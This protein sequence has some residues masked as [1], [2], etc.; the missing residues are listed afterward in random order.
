MAPLNEEIDVKPCFFAELNSC[1]VVLD[2]KEYLDRRSSITDRFR[3][4]EEDPNVRDRTVMMRVGGT[5]PL[6]LGARL[7]LTADVLA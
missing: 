3:Q 5:E 1:V 2:G 7:G 6:V 4:S